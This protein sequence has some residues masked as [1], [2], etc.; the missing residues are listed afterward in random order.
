MIH[1]STTAR[2]SLDHISIKFDEVTAVDDVSLDIESGEFFTLL[3]PSGCGKTTLLRSVAGFYRQS[4]GTIRL[5][6][7]VL[8]DVPAHRRDTGMVF[9]NYAV[10]P[11][12]NVWDNIAYGLKSRGIKGEESNRRVREAI[13]LVDLGPYKDRMPK[14]LS[15]GQ[16]QRVVI[17]RAVVIQPRVLLM[18]EPLA[19]LDAKLRVRL[20][21]ELKVLQRTLGTT[22]VYVTHDQEEALSL[23]DRIAVMSLGKVLQVGTPEQIYDTPASLNVAQFIGEGNFFKGEVVAPK[24]VNVS[25]AL[26]ED[27]SGLDAVGSTQWIGFRPHDAVLCDKGDTGKN[28][29]RGVI[30]SMSYLGSSLRYEVDCGLGQSVSIQSAPEGARLRE[31]QEVAVKILPSHTLVFSADDRE[32]EDE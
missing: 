18:D 19:N 12:L 24:T 7:T 8:D 1:D 28:T 32:S 5:G 14:Q 13:E 2:L 15:G 27:I 22:T 29:L 9:Q 23:S 31:G 6:D 4:S 25:G 17:A 20:R 26:F 11:H 30:G 10:F 16:Q 3:G 21:N